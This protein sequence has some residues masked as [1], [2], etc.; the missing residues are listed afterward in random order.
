MYFTGAKYEAAKN[1]H[2]KIVT[3]RWLFDCMDK[4]RY[5]DTKLYQFSTNPQPQTVQTSTPERKSGINMMLQ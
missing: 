3:D 1:W 2:I 5:L 4:G